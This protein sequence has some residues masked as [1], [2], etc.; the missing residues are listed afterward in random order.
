MKLKIITIKKITLNVLI[1]ED[2]VKSL[3][4]ISWM[5]KSRLNSVVVQQT[6][7][8]MATNKMNLQNLKLCKTVYIICKKNMAYVLY[9]R[10]R[11]VPE[12]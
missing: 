3:M 4:H 9:V 6:T 8:K 1:S 2:Q 10:N 11:E 7:N 5:V 12:K